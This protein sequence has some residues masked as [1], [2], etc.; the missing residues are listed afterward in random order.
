MFLANS[1]HKPIID[2]FQVNTFQAVLATDGNRSYV[3]FLYDDIQL[4]LNNTVIGF[5]AGD[6][7]HFYM[8]PTSDSLAGIET[9]SNI[10][11]PGIYIFRVDQEN[12][13]QPMIGMAVW[14]HYNK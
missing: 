11:V 14:L 8:L 1:N 4:G 6:N 9:T 5:N 7:V 13:T 3:L 12:I 10:G 2:Y